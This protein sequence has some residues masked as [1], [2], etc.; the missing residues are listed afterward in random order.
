ME[1]NNNK[2]TS[3]KNTSPNDFFGMDHE[4]ILFSQDKKTGLK[5]IIAVH[6]TVCGTA[7]SGTR[8]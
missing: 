1:K 2:S 8:I 4:K 7:L 3:P 5:A 6:N